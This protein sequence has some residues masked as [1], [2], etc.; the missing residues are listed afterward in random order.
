MSTV[1]KLKRG[2]DIRLK[3]SAQKILK[4]APVPGVFALKPI[5]FPDLVPKLSVKPGH[6]VEAGSPLFFDKYRPSILFTAPVSGTVKAVIRGER[7]RI[8]EV[9]VVPDGQNK[10][11]A[12]KKGDPKGMSPGEIRDNLL[13][14]GVWPFIRQRPFDL[15]ANPEDTPKAI[16][17]SLFDTAPL[18]PDYAFILK[19]KLSLFQTG[20]NALSGLT[21]GKPI[22]IGYHPE[23]SD[24]DFVNGLEG[25]E[26]HA[27]KG[28]HPAG[29]VGVHGPGCKHVGVTRSRNFD[30]R[31]L[32]D[33]L[34]KVG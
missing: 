15:V 32:S 26:K 11:V 9:E 21:G 25:V 34:L 22:H 16:F 30:F 23:K 4:D 24:T 12:F 19:D 18:A 10:S 7:R 31:V 14:S 5:D 1:K 28:P 27:F 17:I 2:L 8:L 33:Q 6:N 3:G 13:K 29:N 20:L